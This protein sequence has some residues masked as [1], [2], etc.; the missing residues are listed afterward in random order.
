[1]KAIIGRKVGMTQV[2]AQDGT[3]LPVTVIE[4]LPNI[5]LQKKTVEKD[6]YDALQIGFQERRQSLVT[7]PQ[8]GHFKKAN[9]TA[10]QYVKEIQGDELVK[11]N[12]GDAVTVDI[13]QAGEIVDAT[14][15]TKG[16][17]FAGVIK[18]WG[19]HLGPAAH[20]SGYHR[21]IGTLATSGRTNN[22]IHPGRKMPGHMGN[23]QKTILNLTVV[24]VDVEKNALLVKGA[25]PGS[26]RALV[27]IRSA[28]KTQKN[29]PEA[30][31]LVNYSLGTK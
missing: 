23:A 21:G 26:K 6:G 20:G 14:G 4:V 16:K 31:T 25:V 8:A 18:R 10:K 28:V 2:F 12:V 7:K 13:F 22:R 1:M 15:T 5:V 9:V 17:G 11:Y 29:T 24:A 30:K 3:L 19:F 27:S